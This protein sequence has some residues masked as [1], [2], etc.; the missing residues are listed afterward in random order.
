MTAGK[1][2]SP[3][4][5]NSRGGLPGETVA[6]KNWI[7]DLGSAAFNIR[8]MNTLWQ[9]GQAPYFLPSKPLLSQS[10]SYHHNLATREYFKKVQA[11]FASLDFKSPILFKN[12][13]FDFVPNVECE[14]FSGHIVC[15]TVDITHCH[16]NYTRYWHS[17]YTSTCAVLILCHT[18]SWSRFMFLTDNW[19]FSSR[20][21]HFSLDSSSCTCHGWVKH[22]WKTQYRRWSYQ[23]SVPHNLQ[24][25]TGVITAYEQYQG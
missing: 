18:S 21:L 11:L 16:Y 22:I 25:P 7:F 3:W 19:I 14:Y 2:L 12:Y 23:P 15:I 5:L 13:E 24:N 17:S 20:L 10:Y 6:T 9:A 1:F 8:T 4:V